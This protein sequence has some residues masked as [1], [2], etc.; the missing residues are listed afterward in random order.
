M[1]PVNFGILKAH[2][3]VEIENESGD[4]YVASFSTL[5]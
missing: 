4:A 1:V 2:F 3:G 5:Y